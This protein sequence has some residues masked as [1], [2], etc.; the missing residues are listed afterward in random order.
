MGSRPR[1]EQRRVEDGLTIALGPLLR[2]CARYGTTGRG[3]LSWFRNDE[4]CASVDFSLDIT[5]P[6]KA[7]LTLTFSCRRSDGSIEQVQQ[8][9]RLVCTVPNYGGRRWWMVGPRS[10]CRVAKLHLPPG[11]FE[12]ASRKEWGL[13]YRSQRTTNA[14]RPFDKLSRLQRS[15]GCP[16]GWHFPLVRP[17]GMW[18]RTYD[19]HLERYR[20]LYAQC[21]PEMANVAALR[22]RFDKLSDEWADEPDADPPA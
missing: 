3:V 5:D 15:L 10:G 11:E 12:F 8:R 17:K 14:D 22:E 18:K 6:D 4:Q 16:E 13:S 2:G 7:H 9:I 19:R 1:G 21:S 20:H